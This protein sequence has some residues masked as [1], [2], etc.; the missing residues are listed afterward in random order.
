MAEAVAKEC[1]V[2][3]CPSDPPFELEEAQRQK[4]LRHLGLTKA[5]PDPALDS[6]V[7]RIARRFDV[8]IAVVSVPDRDRVRFIARHGMPL[9][10]ATGQAGLC[11]TA[12]HN[13]APYVIEDTRID[14]RSA[15]HPLVSGG[16]GLRFYAAVPLLDTGGTPLGT[17]ALM[18]F[19]P[20]RFEDTEAADL[21]DV[22]S[23]VMNRIVVAAF[24]ERFRAAHR[25][26]A[27][28]DAE[29]LTVCAWSK[30]VRVGDTWLPFDTFLTEVLE[31]DVTH[32]L[33]PGVSTE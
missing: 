24:A 30:Q 14:A 28:I 33:A 21:A 5:M 20:R 18:D 3:P 8:P 13:G 11:A 27:R 26:K 16:F 32:G 4:R 10:S 31:L 2:Y 25:E 6:I 17:V 19:A 12:L 1:I 29:N 15:S 22:A 7:S 9:D 23:Q